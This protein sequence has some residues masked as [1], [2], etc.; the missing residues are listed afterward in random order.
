MAE[1]T[2][3]AAA[4]RTGASRSPAAKRP[5]RLAAAAPTAPPTPPPTPPAKRSEPLEASGSTWSIAYKATA[6]VLVLAAFVLMLKMADQER[7]GPAHADV[8]FG[9]GL[10][11][12]LYLPV[13]ADDDGD[14]PVPPPKGERPPVVVMSHGYSVDRASMSGMARSLARAGYAVLSIDLRGHGANTHA[15]QGDLRDDFDAAVDWATTSPYVDGERLAVLGHSMGA[16]AV[17][18]FATVDE[19]PDAVIP[20]SGGSELNDAVVPKNTLFLVASGDPGQIHD[21]QEELAE[22]L[23]AL[24]GKVT[25]KEISGTDH[26]TVLRADD[27]IESIVGFLDPI[28]GVDR[29]GPAPGL[30]D[31]RMK[32]ATLYLVVVLGLIALLGLAVGQAVPVPAA[33]GRRPGSTWWSFAVPAGALIITM[34]LLAIGGFDLLPLGAGQQIVMHLALTAAVLWGARALARRGQIQGELGA[35]LADGQWVQLRSAG[36]AALA[37]AGVI[38]A[39]LLPMAGV[40][41]RM[42]P[43]A[44]RAVYWVVLS[45]FAA[46]FFLAFEALVRRGTTV[47][48]NLLGALGKVM[49]LLLM[50]AGV[51]VGMLPGVLGLIITLLVLQ[52]VLLEVFAGTV[53]ARGRNTSVIAITEAI[54]IAYV[55]VTLTP[56]A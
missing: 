24:G 55:A 30:D 26:I 15:F 8:Y 54:L 12:T 17:L 50:F 18:G 44:E 46:P 42:V 38:V 56:V 11:A 33:T 35:W 49:L 36:P 1:P 16:S 34:P 7:G 51:G 27:T 31:P 32:T 20:V 19:R 6:V 2:K 21:R 40:F 9:D 43:T 41:H 28:L 10:P 37:S 45:A 47:R 4:A 39:L 48:A 25:S 22:D 52:Y 23:A 5:A 14:L 13:D 29:D 53:Y 3:R